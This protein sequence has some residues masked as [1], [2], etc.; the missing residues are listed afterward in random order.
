MALVL[1]CPKMERMKWIR[2]LA[3]W[4]TLT[5]VVGAAWA[6]KPL[7]IRLQ[8]PL[9]DVKVGPMLRL[10]RALKTHPHE[11]QFVLFFSA[12]GPMSQSHI[13]INFNRKTR[14]LFLW[15]RDGWTGNYLVRYS[16]VTPEKISKCFHRKGTI[17]LSDTDNFE[18]LEDV[19]CPPKTLF[20]KG[21]FKSP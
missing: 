6:Q 14:T 8:Q 10:I 18:M 7:V 5:L 4:S 15:R 17:S 16:Q 21:G 2:P 1:V 11:N 19:G 12:N 3:L 20:S 9:P 13:K